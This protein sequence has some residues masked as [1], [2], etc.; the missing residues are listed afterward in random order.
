MVT[1]VAFS[2]RQVSVEDCPRWIVSG[3]AINDAVGAG[4]GGAGTG[5]VLFLQ[6][7]SVKKTA[8]AIASAAHL[9]LRWFMVMFPRLMLFVPTLAFRNG[10]SYCS[11]P[12]PL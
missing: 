1:S 11:N 3:L 7:P 12:K 9:S 6:A 8:R 2:V 5:A 4:G 10:R